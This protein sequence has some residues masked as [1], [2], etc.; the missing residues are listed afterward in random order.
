MPHEAALLHCSE[1][2]CAAT[3]KDHYW[4]KVKSG[5]FFSMQE[6]GK[7]WCPEHIPEW[8]AAWRAKRNGEAEVLPEVPSNEVLAEGIWCEDCEFFEENEIEKDTC[9]ACGCSRTRHVPAKVVTS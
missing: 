6:P 5:W 3:I 1:T 8:V 7:Q 4:S 2:D 9:P